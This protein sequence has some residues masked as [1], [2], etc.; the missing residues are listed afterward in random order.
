MVPT[1]QCFVHLGEVGGAVEPS[2]VGFGKLACTEDHVSR[3]S[4]SNGIFDDSADEAQT[5]TALQESCETE[6]HLTT[7]SKQKGLTP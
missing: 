1:D 2:R 7:N 6:G 5:P 4:S 3:E